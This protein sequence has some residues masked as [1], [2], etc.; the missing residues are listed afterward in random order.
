MHHVFNINFVDWTRN[1]DS[2]T[3]AFNEISDWNFIFA[4]ASK[5]NHNLT[6]KFDVS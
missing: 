6:R 3:P 5:E 4:E 1:R 2:D